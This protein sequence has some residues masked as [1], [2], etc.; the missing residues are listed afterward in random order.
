MQQDPQVYVN[1]LLN[2][3]LETAKFKAGYE[4]PENKN[5]HHFWTLV[6]GVAPKV[7]RLWLHL[8][9]FQLTSIFTPVWPLM[10]N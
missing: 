6:M 3:V 9:C 2:P 5:R 4:V 1:S 10:V 7:C 8:Y